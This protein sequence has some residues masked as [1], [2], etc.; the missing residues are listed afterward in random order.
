MPPENDT[1]PLDLA[2]VAG[3]VL[4]C[5]LWGGNAVAVKFSVPDFPPVGC[6]RP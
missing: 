5:A 2:G 6:A 3:V 4:C 1:R